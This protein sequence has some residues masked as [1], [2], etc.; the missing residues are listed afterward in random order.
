MNAWCEIRLMNVVT[1]LLSPPHS[2]CHP[3]EG[4]YKQSVMLQLADE[5]YEFILAQTPR[6]TATTSLRHLR[7]TTNVDDYVAIMHFN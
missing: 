3:A 7:L 2:A 1:V 6:W 5:F 4:Q